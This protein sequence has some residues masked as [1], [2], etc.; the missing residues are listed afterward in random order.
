MDMTANVDNVINILRAELGKAGSRCTVWV[1]FPCRGV[2]LC[3]EYQGA[4]YLS[5][6]GPS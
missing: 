3:S 6:R 1:G 2:R 4:P 5:Y